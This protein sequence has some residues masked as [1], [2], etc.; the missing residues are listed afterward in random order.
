[1][2]EAKMNEFYKEQLESR[3]NI[4]SALIAKAWE[5]EEFKQ[6]LLS[7]P[8]AAISKVLQTDI[9]GDTEVRVLEETPNTLYLTIPM[10]PSV[11]AEGELSDQELEAVAGGG[12]TSKI[13]KTVM[14]GITG[15]L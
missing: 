1:M 12:I 9:F 7:N 5:D 8:K 2:S 15:C 6:E 11:G 13:V 14:G 10:K 4:E 3:L